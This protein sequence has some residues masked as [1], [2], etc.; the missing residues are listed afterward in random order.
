MHYLIS[1]P[2]SG[3]HLIR[4]IVE[5][6][7]SQPTLGCSKNDKPV[8]CNKYPNENLMNHVQKDATPILQ[9]IHHYPKHDEPDSIIFVVRDYRECITKYLKYKFYPITKEVRI[10]IKRYFDTLL[11]CLRCN[12]STHM[13]SYDA[14]MINTKKVIYKMMTFILL[15]N[16]NINDVDYHQVSAH[17]D[18]FIEKSDKLT[19]ECALATNRHWGGYNSQSQL[20]FH[21]LNVPFCHRL[22]FEEE[23]IK[24]FNDYN[25]AEKSML[26][27][28]LKPYD[29]R[30]VDYVLCPSG[31]LCNRLRSIFSLLECFRNQ[32]KTPLRLVVYWKSSSHCVQHFDDLFIPMTEYN[33]SQLLIIKKENNKFHKDIYIDAKVSSTHFPNTSTP[34]TT[35]AEEVVTLPFHCTTNSNNHVVDISSYFEYLC[36][37]KQIQKRI[38]TLKEQIGEQYI[39][40]HV[41]RTDHT[42]LAKSK[43][44]FTTN[45][46]FFAFIDNHDLSSHF[47]FIY[48]ATDNQETQELFKRRYGTRVVVNKEIKTTEKLRQTT[49]AD[50]VVDLFM[51]QGAVS[52]KGSGYSSFSDTIQYLRNL[53]ESPQY[54]ISF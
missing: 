6:I 8:C 20:K 5:Y 9:K 34:T 29:M 23:I 19:R 36:P 13:V 53:H 42:E 44:R 15:N 2:R 33:S 27:K 41:R 49:E 11:K 17:M 39:A 22:M 45:E 1:Y 35:E 38:S 30:R 21:I 37:S 26:E 10:E 51:C 12:K 32:K 40:L 24:V 43:K 3:N 25:S 47:P 14:L 48:L 50:A 18:Q 52:F 28:V 16:H 4:F 54:N 31:G 46:D 7:T